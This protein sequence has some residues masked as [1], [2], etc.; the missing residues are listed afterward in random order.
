M[1]IRSILFIA[2]IVSIGFFF[3]S[4][5]HYSEKAAGDSSSNAIRKSTLQL[6]PV[7]T[8]ISESDKKQNT[9]IYDLLV[10]KSAE[11]VFLYDISLD[12]G[13]WGKYSPFDAKNLIVELKYNFDRERLDF[14]GS[15]L[16]GRK[17]RGYCLLTDKNNLKYNIKLIDPNY[18]VIFET[19]HNPNVDDIYQPIFGAFTLDTSVGEIFHELGISSLKFNGGK[20]SLKG[21][22]KA[23]KDKIEISHLI[24]HGELLDMKILIDNSKNVVLPTIEV[25]SSHKKMNI[26]NAISGYDLSRKDLITWNDILTQIAKF[27]IKI[28]TK[29]EEVGYEGEVLKDVELDLESNKLD[30]ISLNNVKFKYADDSYFSTTGT[31]SNKSFYPRYDGKFDIKDVPYKVLAKLL[32]LSNI[33]SGK[34]ISASGSITA[35]PSVFSLQDLELREGDGDIKSDSLRYVNL[36]NSNDI[37]VGDITANQDIE[38]FNLAT[39]FA[40][41]YGDRLSQYGDRGTL[42]LDINLIKNLKEKKG[43]RFR[44]SN[45]QDTVHLGDIRYLNGAVQGDMKIDLQS[46]V[47]SSKFQGKDVKINDFHTFIE[48]ALYL[49]NASYLNNKVNSLD[50]FE[51]ANLEGKNEILVQNQDSNLFNEM[52]CDGH[53]NRNSLAFKK[54]KAKILGKDALFSGKVHKRKGEIYYNVSFSA[55]NV[56]LSKIWNVASIEDESFVGAEGV[57]DI[58]GSVGSK[59]SNT[60]IL[61]K[62]LLGV[63]NVRCKGAKITAKGKDNSQKEFYITKG[64]FDIKKGKISSKDIVLSNTKEKLSFRYNFNVGVGDLKVVD[65][66][67]DR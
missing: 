8:L 26:D 58:H 31:I 61:D 6:F 35:A 39:A 44:Y 48:E 20:F 62:N 41:K 23:E 54:C 19:I 15:D 47:L 14:S 59:G 53:F 63:M 25:V 60:Y 36:N 13:D 2:L 56:P 27:N 18:T 38:Y 46:G 52:K 10:S 5:H 51:F 12:L 64:K 67:E 11:S 34:K 40:K 24:S 30:E 43:V 17:V 28:S 50:K 33:E 29:I 65:M 1:R 49:H 32:D 45:M 7:P 42:G 57:C 4:T 21:R 16:A 3:Y 37:M 9:I 22:Y 55:N 66:L